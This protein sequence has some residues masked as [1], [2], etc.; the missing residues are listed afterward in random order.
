MPL[1]LEEETKL[2]PLAE[3]A[4]DLIVEMIIEENSGSKED[5]DFH[6]ILE[7][8]SEISPTVSGAY[9]NLYDR[10]PKIKSRLLDGV[11]N[12]Y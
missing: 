6:K 12:V 4:S 2:L 7:L 10:I 9:L 5:A 3:K 8:I 1:T 11:K